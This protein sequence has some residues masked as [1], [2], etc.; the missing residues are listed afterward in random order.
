MLFSIHFPSIYHLNYFFLNKQ[1]PP[2]KSCVHFLSMIFV[3]LF[4]FVLIAARF[5]FP[6]LHWNCS[7]QCHQW[8]LCCSM[9]W[10]NSQSSFY[11]NHLANFAIL[12]WPGSSLAYA[13]E[14]DKQSLNC[15]SRLI[16]GHHWPIPYYLKS[17]MITNQ[18]EEWICT[19]FSL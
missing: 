18:C 10:L 1:N 12:S 9:Q 4:S 7:R 17:N 2:W 6:L 3:F 15:F 11:R 5:S 8:S 19:V 16:W 14:N 13:S